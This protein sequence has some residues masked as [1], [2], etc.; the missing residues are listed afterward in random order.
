[1]PPI[2]TNT[3]FEP[4]ASSHRLKKSEK[5]SPWKMSAAFALTRAFCVDTIDEQGEQLTFR[6]VQRN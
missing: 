6:K 4:S 5:T 1:M 3:S 2:A